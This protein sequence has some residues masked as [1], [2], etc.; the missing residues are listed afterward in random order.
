[1]PLNCQLIVI[2]DCN[3]QAIHCRR[4]LYPA[5]EA[6]VSLRE[7]G[8]RSRREKKGK[9]KNSSGMTLWNYVMILLCDGWQM[10]TQSPQRKQW[11]YKMLAAGCCRKG[12]QRSQGQR[13]CLFPTYP[14]QLPRVGRTHPGALSLSFKGNHIRWQEFAS[15]RV[16]GL[17]LFIK[18]SCVKTHLPDSLRPEHRSPV[19]LLDVYCSV[20]L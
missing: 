1:M 7:Q 2:S 9:E 17:W 16:P 4:N 8:R 5:A 10:W 11:Q 18:L 19:G 13:T 12:K 15:L 14:A 3:Y 6:L 20:V